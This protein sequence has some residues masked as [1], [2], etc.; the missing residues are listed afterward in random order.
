MMAESRKS[1]GRLERV[2]RSGAF[3]VTAETSPPASADAV[4]PLLRAA[5][6]KGLADAVNVT[7][8]AG[9]RAHLSSLVAA[10]TLIQAGIEP[11]LQFTCRDR[12]RLALQADLLGAGA[13]GV[14]NILCLTGDS[15]DSGDEPEA[16]PVFDFDSAGLIACARR[17]RDDGQLGSGREVARAP[18]YMIGGADMPI[19]P[20]DDWQ[21]AA[22]MAKIEAGVDFVQTQ[23]CFDMTRCRRYLARLSDFGIPERLFILIGIGPLRSAGQ[24]RW[25]R[26][27][28][29]GVEIADSVVERLEGATDQ[30]TEG[31]RICVE[32]IEQLQEIPGVAGAHLMAPRQEAA[33]AAVIAE[34]GV[35]NGRQTD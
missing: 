9:A 19:D 1:E 31:R 8:G 3:A 10:A 20:P 13:L 33:C 26:D 17:L 7:D 25:M 23:Y 34:S 2:L 32:L 27:N 14:P 5:P 6:L 30:E 16:K 24:A 12:N 15:P 4:E 21:P 29:F 18:A 11:V 28:L 22:L 35:L